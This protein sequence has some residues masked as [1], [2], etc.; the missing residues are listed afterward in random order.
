MRH[1]LFLAA[2]VTP[3]FLAMPC[4]AQKIALVN[5]KEVVLTCGEGAKALTELRQMFASRQESLTAL[6]GEIAALQKQDKAKGLEKPAR[7][8]DLEAKVKRYAQEEAQ[9]RRDLAAQEETRLKPV[10]EKVSAAIRAYGAEKGLTGVQDR[11]L[12][13]YYD[14]SLDIT[15]EILKRVNQGN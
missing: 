8:G 14:P 2:L 13:L 1:F 7:K 12:Y 15:G 10:A 5:A 4:D 6:R 9:F 3:V 11:G